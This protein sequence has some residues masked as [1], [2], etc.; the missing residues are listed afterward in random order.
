MGFFAKSP[1]PAGS[2]LAPISRERIKQ[3]L[4]SQGWSYRVD[5]DGDI[6]GGWEHGF[7]W[8][9]LNGKDEEILLVRGTWY[10]SLTAAELPLAS[11]TCEEWNRDKLWPKTYPRINDEGELRLH[12][13]HIVDY[14]HGVTD[15]QLL[16]HI[17]TA[18]N[19][20]GQFF[21]HLNTVFPEAAA[22]D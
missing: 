22:D 7:F 3:A 21:E 4:E 18:V 15:E 10:P 13:E 9:F 17:A 2:G 8:F 11:K 19:T 5:A 20:A 6:S 12:A 1:T 16:L 14:E